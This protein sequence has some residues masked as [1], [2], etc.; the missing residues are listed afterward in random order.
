MKNLKEKIRELQPIAFRAALMAGVIF[1]PIGLLHESGHVLICTSE[2]GSFSW[3][4]FFLLAVRCTHIP[5][6]SLMLYWSLG[7]IFG[8]IGSSTLMGFNKIRKDKP[9]L[10]GVLTTVFSQF[11]TFLFETFAHFAYLNNIFLG[12]LMLTTVGLFFFSLLRFFAP[13]SK[14]K[15]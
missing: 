10:I 6:D 7:G 1:Y 13:R 12:L 9:L 2:G 4:G 14:G 8:M 15:T 11:V 5:I 3:M